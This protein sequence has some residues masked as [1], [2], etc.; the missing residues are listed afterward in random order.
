MYFKPYYYQKETLDC[1]HLKKKK[2]FI[3]NKRNDNILERRKTS[4]LLHESY[5]Y[6]HWLFWFWGLSTQDPFNSV[7]VKTKKSMKVDFG[8]KK[9]STKIDRFHGPAPFIY[10]K[11]APTVWNWI[12][13]M[14]RN[15]I[16]FKNYILL[17]NEK[18]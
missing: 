18:L 13:S 14:R 4:V 9:W 7:S 15:W 12:T 1:Y 5:F 10:C 11:W 8:L 6:P 17:T 3:E 16:M 2:I